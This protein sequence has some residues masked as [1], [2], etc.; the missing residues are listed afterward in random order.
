MRINFDHII[1][2]IYFKYPVYTLK[3]VNKISSIKP[4]MFTVNIIIIFNIVCYR[5]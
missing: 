4:S 1:Q 3:N 5:G 2:I